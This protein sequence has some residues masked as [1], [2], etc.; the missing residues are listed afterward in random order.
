[1]FYTILHIDTG[2]GIFSKK[3]L[4]FLSNTLDKK[5]REFITFT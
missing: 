2:I 4:K 1:M 5:T 3:Q